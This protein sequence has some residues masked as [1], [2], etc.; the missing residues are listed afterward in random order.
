MATITAAFNGSAV[1]IGSTE[2]S[3]TTNTAGPDNETSTGIFQA[4]IDTNAVQ[5]GDVFE[6]NVYK[7]IL[8][9]GS[10]RNI[11][12]ATFSVGEAV[13]TPPFTM[14]YGWDMTIK[15]ISGNDRAFDWTV[16]KIA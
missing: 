2:W 16:I 14:V 6:I 3:L 12:K 5:V 15:K 11:Y 4:D 8:S 10:A 7:K 13:Q 1:T 9:G